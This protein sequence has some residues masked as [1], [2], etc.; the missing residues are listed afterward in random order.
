MSESDNNDVGG[1][2]LACGR[3]ATEIVEDE[4]HVLCYT[5]GQVILRIKFSI[6]HPLNSGYCQHYDKRRDKG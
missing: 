2:C 3:L 5:T 1:N 6:P 4:I